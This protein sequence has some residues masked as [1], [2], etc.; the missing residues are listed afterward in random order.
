MTWLTLAQCSYISKASSRAPPPP[1][2]PP[3][4]PPPQG[5]VGLAAGPRHPESIGMF[6]T[7]GIDGPHQGADPGPLIREQTREQGIES[8]GNLI[9]LQKTTR[10]HGL[11]AE[12]FHPAHHMRGVF[13]QE[14]TAWIP[15]QVRPQGAVPGPGRGGVSG[16]GAGRAAMA[17]GCPRRCGCRR[18]RS[19]TGCWTSRGSQQRWTR[20]SPRREVL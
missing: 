2:P 10:G 8:G 14:T 6:I 7:V 12:P 17:K 19:C 1:V 13:E 20:R 5:E 15:V 11:G 18:W 16:D 4:C 9:V 3:A